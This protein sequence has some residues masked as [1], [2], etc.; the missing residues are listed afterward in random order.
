MGGFPSTE[1]S[2]LLL[3]SKNF[4]YLDIISVLSTDDLS[5]E[6]YLYLNIRQVIF[7][8]NPSPQ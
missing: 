4:I 1:A 6:N 7:M 2:F 8:L 5:Q 3:K